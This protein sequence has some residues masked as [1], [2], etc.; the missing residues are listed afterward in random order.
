MTEPWLDQALMDSAYRSATCKIQKELSVCHKPYVADVVD[1]SN[2]DYMIDQ[3]I[4]VWNIK[5][6]HHQ[7]AHI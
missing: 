3:I 6:L 2:Y 7:D 1:I 4:W 5:G